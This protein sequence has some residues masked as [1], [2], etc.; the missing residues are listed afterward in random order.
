MLLEPV[1]I[2]Y[3]NNTVYSKTKSNLYVNFLRWT[4]PKSVLV[5]SSYLIRFSGEPWLWHDV[6]FVKISR[7]EKEIDFGERIVAQ[8]TSVLNCWKS[9]ADR[10]LSKNSRNWIISYQHFTK[11]FSAGIKLSNTDT[12]VDIQLPP[13]ERSKIYFWPPTHWILPV[14]F[15]CLG[16]IRFFFDTKR[17][18][19]I[20]IFPDSRIFSSN[21][22]KYSWSGSDVPPRQ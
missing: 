2:I 22:T 14:E 11:C 7:F 5:S 1:K 19:P 18:L 15:L 17:C 8:F 20:S 4:S 13:W 10:D 16:K 12:E 3:S 9:K 21:R 6:G